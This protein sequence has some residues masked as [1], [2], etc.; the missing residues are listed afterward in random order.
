VPFCILGWLGAKAG[1]ASVSGNDSDIEV[2][3]TWLDDG[4][5]VP[6][7]SACVEDRR[8]GLMCVA[9]RA[10]VCRF[11]VLVA[12]TCI[13][14]ISA[15]RAQA[16]SQW[17]LCGAS[18]LSD[19]EGLEYGLRPSSGATVQAGGPVTFSGD[20]GAPVTFAVASSP[21]LLSN[22]DVDSG[23]GSASPGTSASGPPMYTF[24]S[25]KAAATPRTLYWT[26]SFSDAS[27]PSCAGQTPI[28]YTTYVRTLTVVPNV[29]Q[30]QREARE[31]TE[32]QEAAERVAAERAAA[33]REARRL[34]EDA[35]ASQCVV[36]SLKGDSLSKARRALNKSHCRLGRVSRSHSRHRGILV[37]IGQSPSL[38]SKLADGTRVAVIL[39][40][41]TTHKHS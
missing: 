20:S 13:V 29:A 16:I 18:G 31:E 30:Q 25:T 41:A 22:P 7:G 23:S 24:I 17:A 9:R 27:I 8:G 4:R 40:T 14:A 33:E 34:Q 19:L 6:T 15:A 3:Q 38:G 1:I 35:K 5:A 11:L 26:V 39:G 32:R 12:P 36:P 21:A 37:V 10:M 28:T 2:H